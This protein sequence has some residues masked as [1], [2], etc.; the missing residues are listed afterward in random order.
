MGDREDFVLDRFE[1]DDEEV[2]VEDARELRL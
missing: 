2:D 1:V